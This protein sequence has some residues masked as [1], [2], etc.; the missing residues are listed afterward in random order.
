M[1]NLIVPRDLLRWI[2]ENRGSLSRQSYIIECLFKLK[3]VSEMK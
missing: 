2:D 3:E 1:T